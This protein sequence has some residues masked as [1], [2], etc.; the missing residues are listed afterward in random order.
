MQAHRE[1]AYQQLVDL[2]WSHTT[3][4]LLCAGASAVVCTAAAV[5]PL[6][7]SLPVVVVVAIAYLASPRIARSEVLA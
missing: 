7:V 1:H 6:A 5:A 2:G 4:S 3:S